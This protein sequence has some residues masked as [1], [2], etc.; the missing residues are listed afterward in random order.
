MCFE[1][2]RDF[3]LVIMAIHVHVHKVAYVRHS[4][5]TIQ[6]TLCNYMYS[7]QANNWRA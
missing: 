5:F 6:I 7:N 3:M 4:K 2:L 1:N